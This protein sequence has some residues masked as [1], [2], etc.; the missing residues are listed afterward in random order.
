MRYIFVLNIV[1]NK[2]YPS[3]ENDDVI[4][5]SDEIPHYHGAVGLD[6]PEGKR[7][8]PCQTDMGENAESDHSQDI[9]SAVFQHPG[10]VPGAVVFDLSF[11]QARRGAGTVRVPFNFPFDEAFHLAPEY[12]VPYQR[13]VTAGMRQRNME[14]RSEENKI[15]SKRRVDDV[16]LAEGLTGDVF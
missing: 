12:I 14:R 11:L 10:I 2:P 3:I 5:L 8:V 1:D 16:H 4:S 15:F 6:L 9:A 7:P 13:I